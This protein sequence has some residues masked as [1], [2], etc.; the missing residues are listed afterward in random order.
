MKKIILVVTTILALASCSATVIPME[1]MSE[2]ELLAYNNSV[3]FWDKVYCTNDIRTGSHIRK[4]VCATLGE[5]QD[6]NS[7]QVGVLF[8]AGSGAGPFR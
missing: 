2:E 6:H 5:L 7:N 4:R 3:D 8:T 1:R